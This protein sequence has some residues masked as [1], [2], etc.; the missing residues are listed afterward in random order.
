MEETITIYYGS[1][2]VVK[3]PHIEGFIIREA[4]RVLQNSLPQKTIINRFFYC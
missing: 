4:F 1:N 3:K 2:V